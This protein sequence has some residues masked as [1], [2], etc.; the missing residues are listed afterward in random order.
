MAVL[1][2]FGKFPIVEPIVLV[3]ILLAIHRVWKSAN[4]S[5][6]EAD[7]A[8]RQTGA[9]AITN[10]IN[11]ATTMVSIILAGVGA[12]LII[13]YDKAV[14]HPALTHLG[15]AAFWGLCAIGLGIYTLGYMSSPSVIDKIDVSKKEAVQLAVLAQLILVF[16]AMSRFALGLAYLVRLFSAP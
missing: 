2:T 16:F 7:V 8:R 12:V 3:A 13:A 4:L 1:H 9:S 14:P 11:G 6:M 15:Y 10:Q 5:S